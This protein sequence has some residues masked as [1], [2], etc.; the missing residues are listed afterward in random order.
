MKSLRLPFWAEL[1]GVLVLA[2]TLS[3]VASL[4]LLVQE[5]RDAMGRERIIAVAYDIRAAIAH[6]EGDDPD[7]SGAHRAHRLRGLRF[8]LDPQP[9]V[10]EPGPAPLRERLMAI[11]ADDGVQDVHIAPRARPS[12]NEP[13]FGGRRPRGETFLVSALLADGRWLNAAVGLPPL[14]PSPVRPLLLTLLLSAAALLCVA[15]WISWR[16]TRPL[17]ALEQAARAMRA[18]E[19]APQAPLAGPA[20]VQAA[21]AAFNAMSAQVQATLDGQRAL[22]A[23]LA[24]DLRTPITA[25][26][27]RAALIDD[28]EAKARIEASLEELS[29]LT[30]AALEAARAGG[31]GE[32]ARAIDMAALADSLCQ[33]LVEL[34]LKVSFSESSP[35]VVSAKPDATRRV[36]R[37]LIENAARYGDGGRVRVEQAGDI[38]CVVVED[39]GPG[40]PEADLARVFDPFVRLE[41]SR[42]LNTGGHGLGLTI[43]RLSIRA[44]GGDITLENR[45]EGGLRAVLSLPRRPPQT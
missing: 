9:Q 4:F 28:A 41:A 12:R 29:A 7:Q 10:L 25:L 15:L 16:L 33:D 8:S 1:A 24:H 11:L 19:P 32:P 43:A 26:R 34:G 38:T 2:L 30:E 27:L 45:S 20:P 13:H 40:I 31:D 3:T 39:D 36:L 22:L 6:A 21:A 42:N 5:R 35:A 18:G 44:Q 37:N 14:P 23:G 17:A